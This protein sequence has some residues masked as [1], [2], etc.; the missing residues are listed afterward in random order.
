[1]SFITD[2]VPHAQRIFKEDKILPSLIIAQACL[3]SKFGQSGLAANG[4]NLFG[5]KG[6][7][8]GD[9]VTMRTA[10]YTDLKEKYYIN[11]AFRKYPSWYESL[12][13]LA[14]LYKNGV[15]WDKNKYAKII[16][17]KNAV[18]ACHKVQDSGYCTDPN[19]AEKLMKIIEE[20]ELTKYDKLPNEN[21]YPGKVIKKGD[22][23]TVVMKIQKAVGA[24][25]DGI[26]GPKTES[27]VK[28]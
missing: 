18:M 12:K 13:D 10:E 28:A 26:F 20:N 5:I 25:Q 9:S 15:S 3:E 19:Y 11:A 7:F 23:G 22:R 24:T 27:A 1:M 8:N 4:K 16:G 14:N 2:L 21:P 6:A 17:E